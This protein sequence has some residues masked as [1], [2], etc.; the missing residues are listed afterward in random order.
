TPTIEV[1]DGELRAARARPPLSVVGGVRAAHGA[2]AVR[3]RGTGLHADA[4]LLIRGW[5][6]DVVRVELD[7]PADPTPYWLLSSRR[8]DALAQAIDAAR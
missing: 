8:P 3:E 2:D 7:D 1:R 4:W 6:P 5:I